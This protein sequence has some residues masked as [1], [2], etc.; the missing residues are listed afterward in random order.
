MKNQVVL[1]D[2]IGILKDLPD[3]SV[4]A[5]ITDPPYKYL[6]HKLETDWDEEIFFTQS[7]RVLKDNSFL[8]FFGKGISL[9]RWCCLADSIGFKFKED[10]IWDK[11]RTSSPLLQIPRTHEQ[12]AIFAK[13]KPSF[14][15]VFINKIDY[16][17][18]GNPSAI[19]D[20]IKRVMTTI[21]Q[22]KT[23]DE[24]NAFKA[25]TLRLPQSQW[26]RKKTGVTINSEIV[27]LT[28][29]GTKDYR[30]LTYGR[31]MPSVYRFSLSNQSRLHPTEKPIELM[32][33]LIRLTTNPGD[34][35][36]DP[37]CGSGTTGLAAKLLD[38]EYFCIEIDPEYH[39]I[40]TERIIKKDK[41]L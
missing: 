39:Q 14:N 19:K 38:R 7:F 1:G 13:G 16:D 36:L 15:K 28:D 27:N 26:N 41:S 10:I 21:R 9:F 17:I 23:L 12:I 4:N 31:K 30:A 22:L 20:S 37:F 32:Q 5:I 35:I 18:L 29:R 6:R 24:L 2:C 33:D 3:K 34:L 25:G 11:I 40:A 8:V